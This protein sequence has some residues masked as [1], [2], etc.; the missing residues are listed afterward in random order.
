MPIFGQMCR[1]LFTLDTIHILSLVYSILGYILIYIILLSQKFESTKHKLSIISKG[2]KIVAF[3]Q[4]ICIYPSP[5]YIYNHFKSL[6][7]Y[8][9][10]IVTSNGLYCA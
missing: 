6:K 5:N 4:K 1:F 8:L 10:A 3:E 2:K 7:D 9:K